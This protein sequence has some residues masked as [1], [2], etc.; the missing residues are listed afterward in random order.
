MHEITS[1]LLIVAM[2]CVPLILLVEFLTGVMLL[3]YLN[4]SLFL[5]YPLP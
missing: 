2:I 4:Q 1:Y 3:T 5:S